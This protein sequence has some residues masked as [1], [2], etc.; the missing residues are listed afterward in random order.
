LDLSYACHCYG[1]TNEQIEELKLAI[2]EAERAS[3]LPTAK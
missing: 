1:L 2:E 3:L